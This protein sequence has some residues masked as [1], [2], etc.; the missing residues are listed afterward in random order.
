[1]C[2][3]SHDLV[4]FFMWLK[5]LHHACTHPLHQMAAFS[6]YLQKELKSEEVFLPL[7]VPPSYSGQET[8]MNK[9]SCFPGAVKLCPLTR[10][11]LPCGAVRWME[12]PHNKVITLLLRGRH[13]FT[14]EQQPSCWK[15]QLHSPCTAHSTGAV[16]SCVH[17]RQS[18]WETWGNQGNG[19][20]RM[21]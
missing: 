9:A 2:F 12:T 6:L 18:T 8:T 19:C 1:M 14:T 15:T 4:A 20:H 10:W 3:V 5:G 17:P 16:R 13:D 7:S 21:V 11:L